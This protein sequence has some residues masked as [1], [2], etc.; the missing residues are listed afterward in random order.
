MDETQEAVDAILGSIAFFLERPA[1]ERIPG[2][3]ISPSEAVIE[4]QVIEADCAP[5]LSVSASR[6]ARSNV[7]SGWSCVIVSIAVRAL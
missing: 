2:L 3:L 4:A 1:E 6:R 5:S 7:N